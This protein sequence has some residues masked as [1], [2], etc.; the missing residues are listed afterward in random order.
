ML[1]N[2]KQVAKRCGVSY[3]T[4]RRIADEGG[5]P[6][7]TEVRGRMLYWDDSKIDCYLQQSKGHLRPTEAKRKSVR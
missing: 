6:P 7:P 4:L 2:K 5:L 3:R 1:L